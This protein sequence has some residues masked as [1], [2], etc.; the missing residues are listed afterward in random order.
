[1]DRFLNDVSLTVESEERINWAAIWSQLQKLTMRCHF[2]EISAHHCGHQ[3]K[4]QGGRWGR[5][6]WWA[7]SAHQ[8]HPQSGGNS[9]FFHNSLS[10]MWN[11]CLSEILPSCGKLLSTKLPPP[12]CQKDQENEEMTTGTWKQGNSFASFTQ[13]PQTHSPTALVCLRCF[14]EPALG[15]KAITAL[16]CAIKSL[17]QGCCL[18]S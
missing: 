9:H 15:L 17:C 3:P 8:I 4:V 2:S 1:M 12:T 18:L 14:R 7:W 5:W 6:R 11:K 13:C 16:W 10:T